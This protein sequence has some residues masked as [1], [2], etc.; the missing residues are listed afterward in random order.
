MKTNTKIELCFDEVLTREQAIEILRSPTPIGDVMC[1]EY[2]CGECSFDEDGNPLWTALSVE[3]INED[4]TLD[5]DY[6]NFQLWRN[7]N[8]AINDW[9]AQ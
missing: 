7:G 9:Y 3:D 8:E 4:G 2:G 1:L 5:E 6:I